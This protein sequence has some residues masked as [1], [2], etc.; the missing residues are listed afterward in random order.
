MEWT[1]TRQDWQPQGG[2]PEVV[3]RPRHRGIASEQQSRPLADG[4]AQRLAHGLAWFGISL[5]LVG[6]FAPEVVSRVFGGNGRYTKPILASAAAVS[7]AALG[8]YC[9]KQ[10]SRADSARGAIRM[11]RSIA[12]NRPAHDIY[13]FWH[14]VENFPRFMYHLKSVSSTGT[15]VSHW[16]ANAPAGGSVEWDSR[17][18]ADTPNEMIAWQS[19][20]GSDVEHAGS[21]RF[22]PL[23]GN[24]GTLVFVDLEYRPPSGVAGKLVATLFNESP[25]Q[26]IYDDLR[27]MK[28]VIETGEVLRSDAVPGGIGSILQQPAQPA[29]GRP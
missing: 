5:G 20:E 10:L 29:G 2:A 6:V 11:T 1:D 16:V 21:V 12:V 17:I 26:Q 24:R 7:A 4:E 22:E 18:T 3:R 8:V 25:E 9:A 19:L 23:D 28:Q 15:G 27:R 14:D 13:R